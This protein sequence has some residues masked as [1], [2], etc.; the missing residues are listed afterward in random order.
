[1]QWVP[2]KTA[3]ILAFGSAEWISPGNQG[4]KTSGVKCQDLLDGAHSVPAPPNRP[5]G[6]RG[7]GLS[8][9]RLRCAGK[10]RRI[11][12]SPQSVLRPVG[13]GPRGTQVSGG[14]TSSVYTGKSGTPAEAPLPAGRSGS[15]KTD[16]SGS[17]KLQLLRAFR[18]RGTNSVHPTK[19]KPSEVC[20]ELQ[21]QSVWPRVHVLW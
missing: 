19:A 15:R 14:A 8:H 3:L 1:M 12:E 5:E 17:D 10:A 18:D 11:L 21:S 20:C 4:H 6:D 13:R 2:R 9:W 7:H 16:Q